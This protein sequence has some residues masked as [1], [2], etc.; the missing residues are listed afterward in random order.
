MFTFQ[1]VLK[2]Q[3][4]QYCTCDRR[5]REGT[6]KTYKGG[7][8]VMMMINIVTA[9]PIALGVGSYWIKNVFN[10]I[11]LRL[12]ETKAWTWLEIKWRF[13]Q[14]H[15]V[16]WREQFYLGKLFL[17][18]FALYGRIQKG[19]LKLTAKVSKSHLFYLSIKHLHS[20]YMCQ[21]LF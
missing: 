15:E 1:I 6:T 18:V 8:C 5:Y 21:L 17:K 10:N 7:L 3:R 13:F 2:H 11:L 14:K 12:F 9:S 20:A 19:V 4:R 16:Y